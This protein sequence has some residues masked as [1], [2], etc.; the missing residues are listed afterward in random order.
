[1]SATPTFRQMMGRFAT[2]VAVVLADTPDGV[3]GLT[4]N[5]LT[6]LSLDPSLLLFCARN[7][8]R[9][10][11]MIIDRGLFSVNVLTAAQQDVSR[12]FAGQGDNWDI[13]DCRRSGPWLTIPDSNGAL[14]CEV[15]CVYP[16]GDHRI[17][18]G[19][20]K[21]ILGPAKAQRPL[22]YHEGRYGLADASLSAA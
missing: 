9:T 7:E 17:I 11:R 6:S 15:A 19:E 2:G 10:A 14:F 4:V 3:I 12:R 20:V 22:V 13:A 8:S 1:L 21:D 5:S 16:G 18:V